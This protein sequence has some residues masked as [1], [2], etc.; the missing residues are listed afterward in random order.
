[1]E[2]EAVDIA[3]GF[4]RSH[5]IESEHGVDVVLIGGGEFALEQGFELGLD[6]FQ[7]LQT[8]SPLSGIIDPLAQPRD[9]RQHFLN[10]RRQCDVDVR[11]RLAIGG[12]QRSQRPLDPGKTVHRP[13]EVFPFD[14]AFLKR[15]QHCG[16]RR[17]LTEQRF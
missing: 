5:K 13:F 9:C 10:L 15:F 4:F 1:M 7:R 17:R 12:P 2:S 3:R 8:G 6:R 14:P 11:I 16:K